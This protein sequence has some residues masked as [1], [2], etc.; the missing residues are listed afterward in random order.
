M[1][2]C[3]PPAVLRP[4]FVILPR[5]QK[6]HKHSGFIFK[7]RRALLAVYQKQGILHFSSRSWGEISTFVSEM[8]KKRTL[9]SI[10]IWANCHDHESLCL[11]LTPHN[12][13]KL[14]THMR[15]VVFYS[16]RSF[17]HLLFRAVIGVDLDLSFLSVLSALK[18]N[19]SVEHVKL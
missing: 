17:M 16:S 3:S 11:E 2:G 8:S 7:C 10:H 1:E 15:V 13:E 12:S 19:T 18:F 4:I 6:L 5:K 14:V 9:A